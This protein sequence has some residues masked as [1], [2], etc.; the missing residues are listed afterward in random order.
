MERA[1]RHHGLNL[2][3]PRFQVDTGAR[4]LHVG[5]GNW[6]SIRSCGI[7]AATADIDMP[8]ID[9]TRRMVFETASRLTINNDKMVGFRFMS[10]VPVAPLPVAP[11][12][13]APAVNQRRAEMSG[14]AVLRAKV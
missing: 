9:H 6:I 1:E 7:A 13:P 11:T 12:A 8:L 5:E 3:S 10:P 2:C 14:A 4:S